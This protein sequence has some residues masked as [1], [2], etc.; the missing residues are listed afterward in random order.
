MCAGEE[1][2]LWAWDRF[3][4]VFNMMPLAAVIEKR[5]I[6]MHGALR[7]RL[8]LRCCAPRRAPGLTFFLLPC[9][10]AGGIGKSIESVE[11]LEKLQRPLTMETGGMVLMDLLWR[12]VIWTGWA[13][14]RKRRHLALGVGTTPLTP[15]AVLRAATPPRTMA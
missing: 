2:G 11:Q 15:A 10:R 9:T 13:S 14:H 8:V 7:W 12:C 4:T 3:N 1:A 5:V 6:C